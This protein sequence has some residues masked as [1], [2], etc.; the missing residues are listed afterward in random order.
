LGEVAS[1]LGRSPFFLLV[2]EAEET[3]SLHTKLAQ[4]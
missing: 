2:S 3:H 4:T 1:I